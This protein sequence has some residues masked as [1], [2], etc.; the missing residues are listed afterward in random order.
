[1]R[2]IMRCEVAG[3]TFVGSRASACAVPAGP[4]MGNEPPPLDYRND[5]P[6]EEV[7]K[8]PTSWASAVIFAILLIV[9][10]FAFLILMDRPVLQ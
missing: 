3:D 2:R 7:P 9:A 8:Y 10:A 5:E 1:M 6:L 4:H